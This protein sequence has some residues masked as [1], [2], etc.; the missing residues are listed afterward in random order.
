MRPGFF[1]KEALRALSRSAAPSLA[2][3]FG[4][5][6]PQAI[7]A[8]TAFFVGM[9]LGAWGFGRLADRIGRRRVLAFA[10][11][12]GALALWIFAVAGLIL[13]LLSSWHLVLAGLLAVLALV[14]LVVNVRELRSG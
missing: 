8:G 10:T 12:L 5:T 3:S 2:A 4:L 7:Q 13:A 14:L 11:V 1:F 6:I 9:L